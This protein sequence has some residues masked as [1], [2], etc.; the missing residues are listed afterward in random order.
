MTCAACDLLRHTLGGGYEH[1]STK[2][3][4]T[5]AR[6]D[7]DFSGLFSPHPPGFAATFTSAVRWC[8]ERGEVGR[9]PGLSTSGRVFSR[10]HFPSLTATVWCLVSEVSHYDHRARG[11]CFFPGG[12]LDG[13][14]EGQFLGC[15]PAGDWLC[16]HHGVGA[17]LTRT[18]SAFCKASTSRGRGCSARAVLHNWGSLRCRRRA[19]GDLFST[20][21]IAPGPSRGL[22]GSNVHTDEAIK[23]HEDGCRQ[24]WR[25]SPQQLDQQDKACCLEAAGGCGEE[26]RSPTR[27]GEPDF[28]FC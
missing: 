2:D 19:T 24:L 20:C 1:P 6:E 7:E 3:A 15:H 27:L 12:E 11:G 23:L 16:R 25:T 26:L 4:H 17:I 22:G 28:I 8:S 14:G 13:V 18:P 9:Y 10:F 5:Y 21:A